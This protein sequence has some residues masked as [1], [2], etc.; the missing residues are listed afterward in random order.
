MTDQEETQGTPPE[1]TPVVVEQPRGKRALVK[2]P[3]GR[4]PK[5]GAYSGLEMMALTKGKDAE[6]RS[7][8]F[9]SKVQF[10]HQDTLVIHTLASTL[11][12]IETIDRWLTV[13][14]LFDEQGQPQAVLKI[15]LAAVN[16]A[17][18]LC[19]QLGL[20]PQSRARLGITLVQTRKTL[21][22]MMHDAGKEDD[23]AEA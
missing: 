9:E 22:S 18:R 5:H 6:I 8:L 15:W 23:N 12:K 7:I 19:D 10:G 2:R 3:Q 1:D 4:P 11:A 14:G 16:S 20:T 17:G 13:H 21:G